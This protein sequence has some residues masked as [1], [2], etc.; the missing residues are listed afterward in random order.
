[1]RPHLSLQ[2]ATD[3]LSGLEVIRLSRPSLALIDLDLPGMG[4]LSLLREL[5]CDPQLAQV[6][7]VAVSAHATGDRIE[8]A[9]AAGFDD[10]LVKPFGLAR[11]F[12]VVDRVCR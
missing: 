12:E 2:I 7:C 5:R 3:G 8:Q 9:R 4:G 11:L 1:M 10:Y 6:T